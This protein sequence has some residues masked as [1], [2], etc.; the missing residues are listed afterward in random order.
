MKKGLLFAV[1][2][3]AM[4]INIQ[5]LQ[6]ADNI[7]GYLLPEYY[8]VSQGPAAIEGQNGLWMRR[9]YFGYDADLGDGWS[10]R[11]RFEMNGKA[12]ASDKMT[13]FVK[14]AHLQKKL[15]EGLNLI[16]GIIEPPSFNSQEKF[17]DLRHVEKTAPD[18][19]KFAS[20]RDF[21]IGLD[22]KTAGGLLYTI[23]Y[24]N[25]SGEGGDSDKGKAIYGR[26]GYETKNL[27]LEANAHFASISATATVVATDVTYFSAFAGFKGDWGRIGAGYTHRNNAP[28][29]GDSKKNGIISAFAAVNLSKNTELYAR[30]DHLTDINFADVG[31]WVPVLAKENKARMMLAGMR[32]KVHKMIELIPNVKY[33]FYSEGPKGGKPDGDLH[34][35]LTAKISFKSNIL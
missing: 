34:L 3:A 11:V 24:G 16:V 15:A 22:G 13:P 1:F 26:I 2:C 6:G 31:D 5:P 17:W 14:N 29:K 12:Y 20:S 35:L 4:L 33:V 25:Y 8:F 10:A 30:Y 9:I 21:A 32:F 27:F 19:F 28:E 18:F 7:N 23:M